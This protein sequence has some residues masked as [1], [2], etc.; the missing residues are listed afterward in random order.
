MNR[1]IGIGH[2]DFEDV[3]TKNIFYVDKTEFI[4]E[5]WEENDMVTLI[6]RPRRFGKTL[7]MSMVEKFFSVDY[8]GRGDLFTGLSIWNHETYRILQGTYPVIS[9]SFANVKD[10]RYEEAKRRIAQ[11]ITDLYG[12]NRFLL[13]SGLLN[14]EERAFFQ[15]ININ[16]DDVSITMA[17]HRLS[18]FLCRYYKKKVIILLDEYDTPMLEAWVNGFWD[19]L[20]SFT[21]SFFNASFKTNPYLERAVMT[22]ITRISKESIFSDLNNLKVVSVTSAEYADSFGFREDEVFAAMDAFG[23]SDRKQEVK[24]WYD[25]FIFGPVRDLY[26]PWS[27]INFLDTG[28]LGPYWANTS[29]NGLIAMLLQKANPSIKTEFEQLLQGKKLKTTV[30]EQVVFE[31]LNTRKNAI[32]SLLLSCGYLKAENHAMDESSGQEFFTLSLTNK[33][34]LLTFKAMVRSWFSQ[35][36]QNYNEFILAL[37]LGDLDAMNE[38]MNRVSLNIFSFFDTGRQPSR[39][40]PERFYHGF[41][42]GLIVELEGNYTITS[43][44][45]SGF[46]RY[47]IVLEPIDHKKDAMILEF[48]VYNPRKETCLEDTVKNALRQIQEKNYAAS[49]MARGFEKQQIRSYGFAFEGKKVLIGTFS[50]C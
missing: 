1:K 46:G 11:I 47:D 26:N 9:L 48:K 37:L 34:V 29:S 14:S 35:D 27:V 7:N 36:E 8:A 20:T 12:R 19:E 17:V 6:T 21:R 3:I 30:D 16:A 22:G 13:Q 43:N 33:E 42:L 5:W 25:G 50:P 24:N 28:K 38:Y 18:E 10:T 23:L 41:V 2:Q 31:Q 49:L 39:E 44:R 15:S 40:E 4:R 45:E 32:W